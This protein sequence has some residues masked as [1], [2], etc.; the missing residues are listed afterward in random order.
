MLNGLSENQPIQSIAVESGLSDNAILGVAKT[1]KILLEAN[2]GAVDDFLLLV[3]NWNNGTIP[4]F[5]A[6]EQKK[7]G[8]SDEYLVEHNRFDG[9]NKSDRQSK[10]RE[11]I[12]EIEAE[13]SPFEMRELGASLIRLADALDQN[14]SPSNV[15][16][17]FH[18]PSAAAQIERNAL[19]LAKCASVLKRQIKL[20]ADFLPEAATV[21]PAWS[22]LLELFI[23]FSGGALVSTKSLYLAARC[24]QTTALRYL[25]SLEAADLITRTR[26]VSDRRVTMVGLTKKGVVGVGR[27]LE[28]ISV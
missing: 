14:W 16:A 18:W 8:D 4:L 28:R 12:E 1:A 25:E 19:E 11:I 2:D 26:S 10:K 21:E 20:R 7:W 17:S 22:M 3:D 27:V 6:E 13:W 9:S 23:Q 5:F 15:Q 24:P